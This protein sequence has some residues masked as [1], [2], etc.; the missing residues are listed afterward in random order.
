[1]RKT[2]Q[3]EAGQQPATPGSQQSLP[4]GERP[5]QKNAQEP[6]SEQPQRQASAHASG[7]RSPAP[8]APSRAQTSDRVPQRKPVH[9]QPEDL[10]PSHYERDLHEI[11]DDF[12]A[13]QLIPVPQNTPLNQSTPLNQRTPLNQSAVVRETVAASV[14]LQTP[15]PKPLDPDFPNTLSTIHPARPSPGPSPL[16]SSRTYAYQSQL[17]QD[18]SVDVIV[19]NKIQASRYYQWKQDFPHETFAQ[20]MERLRRGSQATESLFRSRSMSKL[21]SGRGG[22]FSSHS[23]T[24]LFS[25]DP[26]LAFD[27]SIRAIQPHQNLFVQASPKQ[28]LNPLSSGLLGSFRPAPQPSE[29]LDRSR[30]PAARAG[31]AEQPGA[32]RRVQSVAN[33]FGDSRPSDSFSL[34]TCH[35]DRHGACW[36]HRRTGS[37]A[38]VRPGL[39]RESA[40]AGQPRLGLAA[41][42]PPRPLEPHDLPS[43]LQRGHGLRAAPGP[44][45]SKRQS[46]PGQP[47]HQALQ[48]HRHPD[49]LQHGHL[50]HGPGLPQPRRLPHRNEDLQTRPAN[51]LR[52]DQRQPA[53][54]ACESLPGP[55]DLRPAHRHRPC[56]RLGRAAP[57][58]PPADQ[59]T[60]RLLDQL[61]ELAAVRPAPRDAAAAGRPRG[62]SRAGLGLSA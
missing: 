18:F 37:P 58:L 15:N 40:P 8:E 13:E 46:L 62:P 53:A 7:Q 1:V 21:G 57:R 31:S 43:S 56:R 61:A 44:V 52:S 22:V 36:H 48:R 28:A 17:E 12:A 34:I 41:A 24:N 20:F 3:A 27:S 42:G 38:A 16:P 59:Q 51:G 23:Q 39:L 29:L 6:S 54:H 25:T 35:S 55:A 60:P 49:L 4:Q 19:L 45:C 30:W 5:S 14:H 50:R 47:A 26:N 10:D 11:Q 33:V 2:G 9:A 32:M